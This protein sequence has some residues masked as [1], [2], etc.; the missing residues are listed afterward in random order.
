[1]YEGID[2]I[3]FIQ[4]MKYNTAL[5]MNE[6]SPL[7]QHECLGEEKRKPLKYTIYR[8]F[9]THKKNPT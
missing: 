5:N 2:K 9:K 6:P 3:L 8:K 7:Y 4:T 1:M